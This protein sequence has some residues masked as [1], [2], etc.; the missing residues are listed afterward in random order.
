[1]H[2]LFSLFVVHVLLSF[3]SV[4][5]LLAYVFNPLGPC[6][7][8]MRTLS[9]EPRG[10][11][12]I[13][14]GP[15]IRHQASGPSLQ[16]RHALSLELGGLRKTESFRTYPNSCRLLAYL[17]KLPDGSDVRIPARKPRPLLTLPLLLQV[18]CTRDR[19]PSRFWR[20]RTRSVAR[21]EGEPGRVWAGGVFQAAVCGRR[22]CR[23]CHVA[24]EKPFICKCNS[25]QMLGATI[26]P[27]ELIWL[28]LNGLGFR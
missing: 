17:T 11:N 16:S 28:L 12:S 6:G 26:S 21:A 18:P 13:L 9:E 7:N 24:G 23:G 20:P 14:A 22:G 8:P 27:G 4:G 15:G 5:R 10:T 19:A 25:L 1:V 2:C 3:Q